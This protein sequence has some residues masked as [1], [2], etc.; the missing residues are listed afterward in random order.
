VPGR[1]P[2]AMEIANTRFVPAPRDRVW[3]ALNDPETL[4]ACIPGCES[5]VREADDRWSATVVTKIGPVSARFAG[6]VELKDVRPPEGYTLAFAGQGGA[7]GFA[8]GEAKVT[9]TPAD[10]GTT[11]A[12]AANAQI[13]GKL[14]QIGSRLVDGA[15]ASLA[16]EFFARFVERLAPAAPVAEIAGQAPAA[17]PR[18][19]GGSSWVRWVAIAA[20]A[21]LV[22]WLATG[23]FR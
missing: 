7:A 19:T 6:K 22:V 1:P 15:A 9:L 3:A 18:A 23:G 8:N 14:A 4:K 2:P 21:A 10:G 20:I 16:D 5:F 13:G 12:Y 17:M 11:L